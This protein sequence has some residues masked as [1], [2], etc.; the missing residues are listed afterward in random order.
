[1]KAFEGVDIDVIKQ[2]YGPLFLVSFWC[3]HDH[4]VSLCIDV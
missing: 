2:Q 1:M 4:E 3:T